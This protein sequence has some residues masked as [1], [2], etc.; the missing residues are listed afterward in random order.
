M[1][2][3]TQPQA[4]KDPRQAAQEV[5]R[6]KVPTTK[7]MKRLLRYVT[8]S[9][10]RFWLAMIL[11][12]VSVVLTALLPYLMG[13]AINIIGGQGSY[14][15]LIVVL[16]IMVVVSLVLW[17]TGWWRNRLMS[18][19]AEDGLNQLRKE[20][21]DHIQTLSLNFFDRQP[22][23]ELMSSVTNDME[24]IGNFFS[25]GL[26]QAITAFMTIVVVLGFML[27]LSLPLTITAVIFLPFMLGVAWLM[28]RVAG[29]GFTKL[30]EQLGLTNGFMEETLAGSK[31]L[32]AYRQQTQAGDTMED[33]SILAR[34]LGAKSSLVGLA[35]GPL[36]N[37]V[38]TAQL[39]FIALVGSILAIQGTIG[40]GVVISFLN[41]SEMLQGP[42]QQLS[43]IY[44]TVLQAIAGAHRVFAIMDET[45]AVTDKPA[46]QELK[47]VAGA[48]AF[49]AVDFSYV[50]GRKILRN[51]TFEAKPG[52][53][54]G[55]VG[56]TGAGKSTIMNILTRYYDLDS[57]AI[58]IDGVNI[59][60]LTQESLRRSIGQV[61][62]EAFL[63]SDTVMN[64]LKYAREGA[65]DEE[66][67]AAAKQANAHDFIMQLGNGYDTLL[68]ERGA[69][70]SQGQRQM[71]TIARAMVANP[72]M[73]VLDEAT[74]N[75]DTRTEKL[76][77]EGLR[78]LMEGK[79][80]FVVAH[81][82][83]TIRDSDRIL[84]I[85]KGEIIESGTH[86]ELMAS[87]GFY[88]ELYMS[89]FKG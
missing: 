14:Q 3:T 40:L 70:L 20:L 53:K 9:R 73:L 85:N 58:E 48:V 67:I 36:V 24:V 64:N 4:A 30:Q 69:N 68:T 31:T 16:V 8:A 47:N 13:V 46:A 55:L 23:G 15:D 76:I 60:D 74:S 63:F 1:S 35:T 57:G 52:Q 62:Q 32:I 12:L 17:A 41:Y 88:F 22:I 45:P 54:I 39:A 72:K 78:K 56:P 71:I 49:K 77:Q 87:K 80:S 61:L 37:V 86:D 82:L 84:V 6:P 25:R 38:Q 2:A 28:G 75:V 29:P 27:F 11:V 10:G 26:S 18:R 89:Q 42:V 33:L 43:Q 79:T 7:L 81:R 5:V 65:T 44:N 21:F 51:N 34:D 59:T 50:P 19:L 83:S 66:C